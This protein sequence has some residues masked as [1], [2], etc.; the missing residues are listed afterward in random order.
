L[1]ELGIGGSIILKLVD[2]TE[3]G[4]EIVVWFI[5]AQDGGKWWGCCECGDEPFGSTKCGEF[6]DQL[7]KHTLL[8]MALLKQFI[9]ISESTRTHA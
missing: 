3:I 5:L 9:Y 6:S 8:Q 4:V 7:R 1:E 2:L